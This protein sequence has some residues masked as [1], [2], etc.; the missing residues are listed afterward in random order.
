MIANQQKIENRR[1]AVARKNIEDEKQRLIDRSKASMEAGIR[2]IEN[3][4]KLAAVA[5]SPVPAFLLFLF[6]SARRLR[7]EQALVSEDR[8]VQ[9]GR[10]K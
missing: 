6:V 10:S 9:E 3:S 5:L 8:Y 4:I 7:R 1:L 2:R